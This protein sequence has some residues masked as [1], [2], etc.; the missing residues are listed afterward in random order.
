MLKG[1][2]DGCPHD[3]ALTGQ[4]L[5]MVEVKSQMGSKQEHQ[6]NSKQ[7]MFSCLNLWYLRAFLG[8]FIGDQFLYYD[9]TSLSSLLGELTPQHYY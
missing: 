1:K 2:Y 5:I 4:E 3:S 7:N 8:L 9:L 6:E